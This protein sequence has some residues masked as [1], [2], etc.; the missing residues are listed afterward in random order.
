MT[1]R[2]RSFA[3]GGAL[4]LIVLLAASALWLGR[5]EYRELARDSDETF[6][7]ETTADE[8]VAPGKLRIVEDS[9]HVSGI[10]L[11]KLEAGSADAGTEAFGVVLDVRP[12]VEARGLLPALVGEVRALRSAVA[13]SE[14]EYRRA[15]ILFD[16]DRNVSER[17]MRAAEAQW[18]SDRERLVIAEGNERAARDALRA[19]W[20]GPL[21]DMAADPSGVAL[22]PLLDQREVLVAI[23]VPP[24]AERAFRQQP[25][26]LEPLGGG[27]RVA[28]RYVAPAPSAV[29]GLAG[30]PLLYRAPN[31]GLRP[32]M[33][34]LGYLP[35]GAG[36]SDGVVV[37]ESAIIWFAGQSWIYLR[38]DDDLFVRVPVAATRPVPGGWLDSG[39]GLEPGREV[40]VTGAQ[41]L[42]SEE[43]EYQIRNE[44]DD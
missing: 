7:N 1:D 36:K 11:A 38:E 42:L 41:L 2:F 40:V 26:T 28:A 32:A 27:T 12:L 16:D 30:V 9:R 24:G 23:A 34:V 5:D 13:A 17:A 15:K 3:F 33:R 39:N 8:K 25:L 37:P 6:G 4:V 19:S 10:V 31:E 20:G 18:K 22:A 43:L 14:A 35:A 29:P 21:A 44:N